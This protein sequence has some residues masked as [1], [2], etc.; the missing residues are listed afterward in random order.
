MVSHAS[1]EQD[2]LEKH[3]PAFF[4][5]T[6]PG[7]P[8]R[9]LL[10]FEVI[11]PIRA[12][13]DG[14]NT[15]TMGLLL[16]RS[17]ERTVHVTGIKALG[18]GAAVRELTIALAAVKNSGVSPVGYYVV[19]SRKS[20]RLTP[21]Q[22]DLVHQ[23]FRSPESIVLLVQV[24]EDPAPNASFFFWD[25]GKFIG[26]F[27]FLEFPFDVDLLEK[28]IA[29]SRI[30]PGTP[31]DGNERT[32]AADPTKPALSRR[33]IRWLAVLG[34]IIV[35]LGCITFVALPA[36]RQIQQPV[37][38]TDQRELHI[39]VDLGLKV[40]RIGGDFSVNWDRRSLIGAT[41][42]ALLVRDGD[43]T[44]ELPLTADELTTGSALLRP[45]NS[46]VQVRLSVVMPDKST[47]SQSVILIL[48]EPAHDNPGRIAQVSTSAIAR[49]G[50]ADVRPVEHPKKFEP[51]I[52]EQAPNQVADAPASPVPV[53]PDIT[54][55]LA[56]ELV[57]NREPL[58]T[59]LAPEPAAVNQVQ[60]NPSAPAGKQDT[61]AE[62]NKLDLPVPSNPAINKPTGEQVVNGSGPNP[63]AARRLPTSVAPTPIVRPAPSLT[64]M[65]RAYLNGAADVSVRV[66]VDRRGVVTQAEVAPEQGLNRYIMSVAR[67][68]ALLWRFRPAQVNGI[69]VPSEYVIVFRF[70]P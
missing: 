45:Q 42:G 6:F 17:E 11:A 63:S 35:L 12:E 50:V 55:L 27:P 38:Q 44:R 52:V 59:Q 57:L 21:E 4:T 29:G 13:V 32:A 69:S 16:G 14:A 41:L 47:R 67:N 28:E 49:G 1:V 18:A 58:A 36:L 24:G 51:P 30:D 40:E 2:S 34:A 39:P 70:K 7:S 15:N 43:S 3:K 26:D 22:L 20:L 54:P 62:N 19:D 23:F 25:S 48:P 37:R 56:G 66:W 60:S 53:P 9:V 8:L 33:P 65:V 5:W 10:D 68:T 46:R 31:V 61:L 64:N